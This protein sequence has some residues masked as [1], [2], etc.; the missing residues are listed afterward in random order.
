MQKNKKRAA[1]GFLSGVDVAALAGRFGGGG[2]ARAA[3]GQQGG[4]LEAVMEP[5]CRAV[6]EALEGAG[7]ALLGDGGEDSGV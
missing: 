3:G 2:H 5:L 1:P 4:T 6:E 7:E